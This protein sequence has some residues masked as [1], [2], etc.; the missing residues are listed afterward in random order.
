[1]MRGIHKL[2]SEADAVCH[3]NGN[4]FD[5]PRINTEFLRLGMAPPPPIPNI[6][7]KKIVMSKFAFTSSKLAF[8]GPALE[9]GE[10]VKHEGWDLWKGCLDGNKAAWATMKKYNMQDV[11]LLERL[12]TKVLPWIDGHPNMNLFVKEEDPVC[13]N[14]G[15]KSLKS[16]GLRRA[17]TYIYKRL[18]CL[19]CGKWCRARTRDK[20]EP[21]AKVV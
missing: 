1:M 4:S 15:S 8:V 12:Y 16:N 10:K 17:T 5:I 7:L 9:L 11:A 18:Q 21:T 14:C 20:T 3:F 6:D 13:P 2:L 19:S